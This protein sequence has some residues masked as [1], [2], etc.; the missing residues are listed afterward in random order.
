MPK[1][2]NPPSKTEVMMALEKARADLPTGLIDSELLRG[3][4][5]DETASSMAA[6][7]VGRRYPQRRRPKPEEISRQLKQ[8]A[9]DLDA[10]LLADDSDNDEHP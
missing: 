5:D 8:L 2:I 4:A 6:E 3:I 7:A 9:S 1:R 10:R